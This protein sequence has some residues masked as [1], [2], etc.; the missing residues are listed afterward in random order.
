[1]NKLWLIVQREYLTRVTKKTFILTTLLT[2]L[3]ILVFTLV[4][5]LIFSYDTDKTQK[6]AIVDSSQLL[7]ENFESA[8]NVTYEFSNKDLDTLKAMTLRKEYDGVLYIPSLDSL[9]SKRHQIFYYSDDKL[10]LETSMNIRDKVKA[11]IKDYKIVKMGIDPSKLDNL[12]ISVS[13]DPEPISDN[14][15]DTSSMS[16]V[17]G[18]ILGGVMG[19]LMF[20]IILFYGMM[21]LKSVMEEKTNRIVEIIISSVKPFQLMLGKIIGIGGVGFTQIAIWCILVPLMLIPAQLIFGIDTS[22]IPTEGLDPEQLQQQMNDAAGFGYNDIMSELKSQNWLMIIPLFIF[23]FLGGY[24]IYTSLF[25]AVGSAIG[26]DINESNALMMP[27]MMPIILAVYIMFRVV[28]LPQSNLAI[29]SS[30][31]PLTSP[32]IMPAR[33][34]A[35][36]PVWQLLASMACLILSCVFFIW[37]SGRIYRVGILMYGKKASFKELAK[38]I[39]YKS[40]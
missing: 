12:K 29:W 1:M 3:G 39:F 22:S 6:I 32:I 25:A 30:I 14:V 28:A 5:G 37:L 19:Y 31:F 21:V 18:S 9:N 38:W 20:F 33:L 34:A 10:S 40:N 24:F 26:D 4:A 27:I 17:V 2:P 13:L 23:Y 16:T 11:R 36:V 7:N 15:E 35:G 8:H